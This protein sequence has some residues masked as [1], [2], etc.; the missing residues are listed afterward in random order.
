V[1]EA[2]EIVARKPPV[3]VMFTLEARTWKDETTVR[4]LL[5]AA[6]PSK[7]TA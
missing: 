4:L 1:A 3:D 2:R 5:K 6:R 7:G